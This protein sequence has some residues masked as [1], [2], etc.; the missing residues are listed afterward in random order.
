M[1]IWNDIKKSYHAGSMA[2][3]IIYVNIAIFILIKLL[4]TFI[5]IANPSFESAEIT[6]WLAIPADFSLLIRRPWTIITYQ[7]LHFEF[8]HIVF[9]VLWLYWFAQL[10]LT[11]FS[12]RQLLS[13]YLWGGIWGGIFYLLSFNFLPYYQNSIIGSQMLGASASIL[14]LVVASATAAPN[15]EM[16]LMLIGKVKLKYMALAVLAIDLM[17]ITSV[18]G[19]GHIAHLGGAFAGYWFATTYL[20]QN[21]DL[22]GWIAKVIDTVTTFSSR[23]PKKPKMKVRYTGTTNPDMDFN[24][25][26]I[27]Q[28]KGIDLILEKIKLSGYDSLTKQEKEQLFNASK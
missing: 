27:K 3:K 8:L 9:N 17:S 20:K 4:T 23:K 7:F 18:N 24:K 1:Q 26:K 2:T 19:G 25:K 21:K 28:E 11:H 15:Y 22:T 14:A 13:V 10:F 6:T 12:R 16:H 5:R